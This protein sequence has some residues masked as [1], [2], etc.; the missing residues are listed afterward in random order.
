MRILTPEKMAKYQL[1]PN[2]SYVTQTIGETEFVSS[3]STS[4]MAATIPNGYDRLNRLFGNERRGLLM[5]LKSKNLKNSGDKSRSL[6]KALLLG[7]VPRS[8]WAHSL[9]TDLSVRVIFGSFLV[10]LVVL[11]HAGEEF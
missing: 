3:K 8:S 2:P 10:V 4:K 11:A 5:T 9:K 1:F 7:R 6:T